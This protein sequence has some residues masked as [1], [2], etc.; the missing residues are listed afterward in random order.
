MATQAPEDRYMQVGS[1]KTRFWAEGKAG[2]PVLLIHGIGSSME[3]WINNIFVL[4]KHHR[5]YALDLPGNGYSDKPAVR[6]TIQYFSDHVRYFLLD[7]EITTATL[8]GNSMGGLVALMCAIRYPEWVEKLILVDP[9]GLGKDLTILFRLPTL[10][11]I[12]EQLTKPSLKGTAQ[13]QKSFCYDEKLVTAELVDFKYRLAAQPGMQAAMLATLRENVTLFGLKGAVVRSVTGNLGRIRA[14]TLVIW[15][16]EDKTIPAKQ[17]EVARRGIK[18]VRTHIFDHC[19]H[20]PQI[21]CAE[22]FNALVLEFLGRSV[23]AVPG[24]Q[25]EAVLPDF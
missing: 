1:I 16:K 10:P 7:Q 6:Y 25:A 3:D 18:D 11:L 9:A 22:A 15:G 24:E 19:G 4:A 8:I 12:G 21:E 2:S 17:A 23:E 20:A 14:P 5:V 13:L